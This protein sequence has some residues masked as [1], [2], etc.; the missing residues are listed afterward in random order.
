MIDLYTDA[1]PNGLKISIA[2]EELGLE[3]R[4]HRLFLGGDQ[5]TPEFTQMNPNQ[6]IPVINDGDLTISESG[7]ILHYLA[8]KTGKLLPVDPMQ[9]A[10]VME[11]LMLQVSGL[12][13][14][15]GQLLVWAAV[16]NNEIPKATER[17]QKEV[18]RLAGV[19]NQLLEGSDY[20]AGET[21]SIADIAF[22]PWVR[23]FHIHPVGQMI[24]I[25]HYKNLHDWFERVSQREAVQRGLLVPEPHPPEEMFK[26]FIS[27]TVGL[28]ELHN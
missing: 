27:S 9:R 6:K 8:E 7:A 12:G 24:Q 26:A 20:F 13:P 3:Y 22:F 1:T 5:K 17:Y 23:M 14:N 19:L 10:K 21:Y 15:F 28:G 18:S 25:S 2:L 4:A 11:M 16:W